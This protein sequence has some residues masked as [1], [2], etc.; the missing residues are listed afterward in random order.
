MLTYPDTLLPRSVIVVTNVGL[1]Y[2]GAVLF[3]NGLLLIGVVPG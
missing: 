1:L 3:I 2:V